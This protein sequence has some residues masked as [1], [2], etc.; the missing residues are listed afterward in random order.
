MKKII[1]G[2]VFLVAIS[3]LIVN[4]K[5]IRMDRGIYISKNFT[6]EGYNFSYGQKQQ[7][8][9]PN[10]RYPFKEISYRIQDC[11]LSK[12]NDFL[13]A[14]EI[15][16]NKTVLSFYE[17]SNGEEILVT[18]SEKERIEDG[19]FIAGE[20][21]PKKI[22]FSGENHI[23]SS[24]TVHLI[25]KSECPTP[26][27]A[28]HELLH[29]LGFDHS[30]NK[31]NIMYNFSSCNQEIGEDLI[32]EINRIYSQEPLADLKIVQASAIVKN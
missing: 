26:N 8:F 12:R 29:A 24:G 15:I 9:Y 32:D 5:I 1:F 3:L 6:K 11:T 22:I 7:Q 25:K 17:V 28:I 30:E 21:G 31:N 16:S 13:R 19:I 2:V 10:M 4:F 18:C 23:I 20:G 27:V 14:T